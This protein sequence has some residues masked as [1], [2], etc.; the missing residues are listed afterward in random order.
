M[1]DEVI[2]KLDSLRVLPLILDER[3][4]LDW[5]QERLQ[6]GVPHSLECI[7]EQKLFLMKELSSFLDLVINERVVEPQG[8]FSYT[9]ELWEYVDALEIC[10]RQTTEYK[11][12]ITNP[13]PRDYQLVERRRKRLPIS[14]E[15]DTYFEAERRSRVV[16]ERT[17]VIGSVANLDGIDDVLEWPG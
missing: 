6:R 15:E 3:K 17:V 10:D 13:S 1:M 8:D 14:M 5:A 4:E 7:R 12:T 2:F 11:D 9:W 16:T